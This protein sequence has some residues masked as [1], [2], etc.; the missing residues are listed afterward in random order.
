VLADK[1]ANGYTGA[2]GS[3]RFRLNRPGSSLVQTMRY[4]TLITTALIALVVSGTAWGSD[5]GK[6]ELKKLQGEWP[7]VA[8][9]V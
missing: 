2:I 3:M 8:N 4:R 9:G 5:D 6:A 1:G 7:I